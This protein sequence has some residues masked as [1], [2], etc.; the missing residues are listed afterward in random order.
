MAKGFLHIGAIRK[1][2]AI[3]VVVVVVVVISSFAF[4]S[5]VSGRRPQRGTVP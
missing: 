5:F 3:R 1:V 2:T 4:L